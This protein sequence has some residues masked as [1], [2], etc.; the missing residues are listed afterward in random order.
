MGTTSRRL[1]P[2]AFAAA[3]GWVLVQP[4]M[5]PGGVI[6]SGTPIEKWTVLGRFDSREA[7]ETQRRD[8]NSKLY[9]NLPE[10]EPQGAQREQPIEFAAASRCVEAASEGGG[11]APDGAGSDSDDD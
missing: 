8:A 6:G 9:A 5:L 3:Y 1:R 7:C 11:A 10:Y 4:P 2:L